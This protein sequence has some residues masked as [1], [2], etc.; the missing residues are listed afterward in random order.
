LEQQ[1][2]G[3]LTMMTVLNFCLNSGLFNQISVS[4]FAKHVFPS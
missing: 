3:E 2:E 1:K 4:H